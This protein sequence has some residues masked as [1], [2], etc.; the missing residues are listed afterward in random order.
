VLGGVFRSVGSSG[1]W[2]LLMTFCLCS[3][4]EIHTVGFLASNRG[5]TTW[6]LR[7][8]SRVAYLPCNLQGTGRPSRG[9]CHVTQRSS[10]CCAPAR[11]VV[12][13][14]WNSL[15][16][17]QRVGAVIVFALVS[18]PTFLICSMI[19]AGSHKRCKRRARRLE[20]GSVLCM[21]TSINIP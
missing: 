6:S 5:V 8:S 21:S 16:T 13:A 1:H 4:G 15:L 20:H 18:V 14:A 7:H 10:P 11:E 2:Y 3:T 12:P 9:S 19:E 17:G